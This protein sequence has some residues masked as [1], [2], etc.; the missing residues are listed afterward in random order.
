MFFKLLKDAFQFKRKNLRN[1]LKAYNLDTINSVLKNY[2]LDLNCRAEELKIEIFID[3][4]N[5]I[6][7]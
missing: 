3:I 6:T 2:G 5:K 1:N 4:A 7:N